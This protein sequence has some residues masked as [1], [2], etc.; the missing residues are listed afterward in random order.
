MMV[1]KGTLLD[2]Y[3]G[4][5]LQYQNGKTLNFV[6]LSFKLYMYIKLCI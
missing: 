5:I 2:Y 4:S 1:P 3:K 6:G